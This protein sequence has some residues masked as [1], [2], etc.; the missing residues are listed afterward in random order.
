M[1]YSESRIDVEIKKITDIFLR[2]G[3]PDNVLSSSIR[4]MIS[5]FN[6]FKSI[7]NVLYIWRYL[8]LKPSVLLI[9]SLGWWCIFLNSVNVRTNFI[10][11]P[12]FQSFQKDT[13]PILQQSEMIYKFQC[14]GD[15]DYIGWTIQRL[16][17]GVK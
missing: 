8:G 14:Q 6:S 16:E 11:R 17:L 12:A 3:Y 9:K 10:I 13:L 1:I 2:N 7:Q 4:S 15:V 5:K